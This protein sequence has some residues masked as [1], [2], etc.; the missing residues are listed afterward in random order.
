M[1]MSGT[2]GF[3][4]FREGGSAGVSALQEALQDSPLDTVILGRDGGE[5]AGD[6]AGIA[7]TRDIPD[8]GPLVEEMKRQGKIV[9]IHAGE[10]DPDDIGAALAL[11]PD[12]LVHCTHATEAHLH[13]CADRTIPIVVCPRSNWALGVADSSRRP[14]LRRMQELGCTVFLG[15]DNAMFVQPDLLQEMSFCSYAYHLPASDVLHMA[16][17]ASEFF[18]SS[19]FIEKGAPAHLLVIDP[20]ASGVQ[21]SRDPLGTIVKR[22]T[23]A[24]LERNVI[25]SWNP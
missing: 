8:L 5:S 15:T 1:L 14:P 17:G 20:A 2:H 6:G 23:P 4:D 18:G 22:L 11:D 12:F 13:E 24:S 10:R 19:Y 3:C 7:G 25:C 16:V 9:G 21:A